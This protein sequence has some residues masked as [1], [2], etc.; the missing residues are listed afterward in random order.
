[1][2]VISGIKW[3]YLKFILYET[4]EKGMKCRMETES[5]GR[6]LVQLSVSMVSLCLSIYIIGKSSFGEH[7]LLWKSGIYETIFMTICV[8]CFRFSRHS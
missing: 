7:M 4:A 2:L 6:R 3:A 1:M 8:A 5:G